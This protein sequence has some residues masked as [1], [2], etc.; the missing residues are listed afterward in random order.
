MQQPALYQQLV[1][2]SNGNWWRLEE[3]H[4]KSKT[5]LIML[6]NPSR[7]LYLQ[8]LQNSYL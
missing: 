2:R 5:A 4:A 1:N 3:I 8:P 7:A 6:D